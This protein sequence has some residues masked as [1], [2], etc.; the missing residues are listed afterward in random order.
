VL[1]DLMQYA[2][3]SPLL[4]AALVIAGAGLAVIERVFALSGP[5]T[6]V[7]GWWEGR[8]LSRLRRE[9]VVRAEKRRIEREEQD[10]RVA[11]LEAA[12][13]DLRAE[14][15]WLRRERADQRAR[16]RARDHYDHT[17]ALYLH[18]MAVEAR[19]A[20]VRVTPPPTLPVLAPLLVEEDTAPMHRTRNPARVPV[21]PR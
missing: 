2:E 19:A 1:T 3:G 8:E 10:G 17:M 16:D 18:D 6:K 5:I 21:P 4:L 7:M 11:D 15:E 12:L 20:G 14:V 13:A 9:A